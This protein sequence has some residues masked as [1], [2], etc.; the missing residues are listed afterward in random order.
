MGK[1]ARM[2]SPLSLE[3]LEDRDLL[4]SFPGP[5]NPAPVP[6]DHGWELSVLITPLNGPGAANPLRI[7][8]G[9]DGGILLTKGPFQALVTQSRFEGEDGEVRA[10]YFG[11]DLSDRHPWELLTL[12]KAGIPILAE[13]DPLST[14]LKNGEEVSAVGEAGTPPD[15]EGCREGSACCAFLG[16]FPVLPGNPWQWFLPQGTAR[17]DDPFSD[18]AGFT[19]G[20]NALLLTPQLADDL[21]LFGWEEGVPEPQ[22]Q[23]VAAAD[24]ELA[25]MAA[26]LVSPRGNPESAAPNPSSA[27]EPGLT[28]FMVGSP[29]RYP[30]NSVPR[31]VQADSRATEPPDDQR[32]LDPADGLIFPTEDPPPAGPANQ[33]RA[34]L[35]LLLPPDASTRPTTVRITPLPVEKSA[36]LTRQDDEPGQLTPPVSASPPVPDGADNGGD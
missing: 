5:P 33:A 10:L 11:S 8:F 31:V 6:G 12:L 4:S 19:D 24:K 14:G 22:V 34:S 16:H 27:V 18:L 26:Y 36:T 15:R 35:G 9:A 29:V 20:L 32:L 23:P 28:D 30:D 7:Q 1:D 21:L 3:A 13:A 2:R 17:T 25:I